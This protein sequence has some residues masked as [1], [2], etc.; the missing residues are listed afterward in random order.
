MLTVRHLEQIWM[1]NLNKE[2][3][4]FLSTFKD[5]GILT[6]I[7]LVTGFFFT[8]S[9]ITSLS[10]KIIEWKGFIL[11]GINF[12]QQHFVFPLS[13]AA[14]IIGFN[15]TETEIHVATIT[16][17]A[18]TVGMKILAAEQKK[19]FEKIN[20]KYGSKE[21]P[22]H[23][24]LW[25]LAIVGPIGIWC[26]YGVSAPTIYVWPAA[27][28]IIIYPIFIVFPKFVMSR[29]GQDTVEEN[30]LNYFKGY[31][32]YMFSL[33]A[34]IGMLAAINTGLNDQPAH[35]PNN[36]GVIGSAGS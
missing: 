13:S 8:F 4:E 30:Y 10:N 11:D 35:K 12:Y 27:F 25:F 23:T 16:S 21:K 31:Y 1:I 34:L 15:Y 33:V 9:S 20:E 24:L 19:V 29:H 2:L 28:I 22:S 17:L 7:F 36:A 14:S 26:W 6:K 32:L 5:G 18:I 3:S